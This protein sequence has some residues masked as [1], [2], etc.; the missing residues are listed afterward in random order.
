MSNKRSPREFSGSRQLGVP[1]R[2]GRCGRGAGQT[3][4][5]RVW[6]GCREI[7]AAASGLCWPLMVVVLGRRPVRVSGQ[8][9]VLQVFTEAAW[10]TVCS[11]DWKG[12]HASIACAQL[13][14]P[15]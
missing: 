7:S 9:G 6:A 1:A 2:V 11:D 14:F 15:R 12:H 13:G 3:Q 5:R 10:R 8:N 4:Q